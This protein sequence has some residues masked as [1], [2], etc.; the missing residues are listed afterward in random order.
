M[1]RCWTAFICHTN[2]KVATSSAVIFIL[3]I[4]TGIF[5]REK[6]PYSLMGPIGR[7][8]YYINY[9]QQWI[10]MAYLGVMM[11]AHTGEAIYAYYLSR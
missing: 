9:S 7:M 1:D 10:L 11:A 5:F 2:S 3:C 6:V 4:Q 8:A